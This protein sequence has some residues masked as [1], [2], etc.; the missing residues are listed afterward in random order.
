MNK[1]TLKSVRDAAM[2]RVDVSC[3]EFHQHSAERDCLSPKTEADADA[4]TIMCLVEEIER[5]REAIQDCAK[6]L[7]E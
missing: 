3:C 5:L 4:V 1:R 7:K 6:V 2:K